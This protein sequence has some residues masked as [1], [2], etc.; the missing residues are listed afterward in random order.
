LRKKNRREANSQGYTTNRHLAP[1]FRETFGLATVARPPDPQT[2][3]RDS[4]PPITVW[5]IFRLRTTAF[6]LV[7]RRGCMW[8]GLDLAGTRGAN[9]A[10]WACLGRKWALPLDDPSV[11]DVTR[12]PGE[13]VSARRYPISPCA[14]LV[15][16][17]DSRRPECSG[18]Y[19]CLAPKN[20][21]LQRW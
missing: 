8:C 5:S 18:C 19:G 15:P 14:G 12:R 6:N 17:P 1:P 7:W 13:A 11:A 2:S 9:A 10:R 4:T 16:W 20:R 21:D 3:V